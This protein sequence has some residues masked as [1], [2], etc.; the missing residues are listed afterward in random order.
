MREVVVGFDMRLEN[1]K[2]DRIDEVGDPRNLLGRLL[3][4]PK[5]ESFAC[6]RFVDPYGDT[7]FNRIQIETFIRELERIRIKATTKEEQALLDRLR[8]LAERCQ[9]EPHLYLKFYGD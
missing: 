2:G 7:V 5:D 3:P 6:L 9:S 1:E 4:S 8:A